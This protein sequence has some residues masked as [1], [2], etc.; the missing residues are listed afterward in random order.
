MSEPCD[1]AD[2]S[3]HSSSSSKP[4]ECATWYRRTRHAFVAALR[5]WA[6]LSLCLTPVAAAASLP[7]ASDWHYGAFLDLSYGLDFNFPENHLWR[8]KSTS[9]RVNELAPNMAMGYVRKDSTAA[10][11][12]GMELGVQA[13]YDTNGLVPSPNPSR[14]TPVDGAD[15][16]RHISRA[17]VSYLAPLGNGLTVTVGLFNS[18]IGYQSVYALDNLNYSRSYMADNAPYFMF[19][20][21]AQYP[22]TDRLQVNL[23]AINGY[24]YLSHPNDQMSYGTQVA[25]RLSKE[26]TVTENLYY[27]PDQSNT[28]LQFW[29]FFSDSIVEWKHDRLTL[30]LA[31]D[32]GT[33][34][35][36]EQPGHPRTFWTAAAFYA[37]L[38]VCGPWSVALRP[39]FYWD[40][41]G[42]ISGS[43]QL[44]KAMTTTVE[45][46]LDHRPSSAVIRLEHRYDESTQPGGGFFTRGEVAPGV[47]G[48]AREQHLLL[49]SLILAF[50]S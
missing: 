13:G 41:S 1:T 50:R 12:W 34:N 22:V 45:Y 43:E 5:L 26:W 18:Y 3:R 9:P 7:E 36:A 38:N 6:C 48:L 10:S 25:Y 31:Y 20:V 46:R 21:A 27:G 29:R 24:N 28:S 8:N 32:F 49:L 44:L 11:R 30:A 2:G 35:A 17:N 47:I 16:L 42:R 15:L 33:E 40:R 19:G 23:Y 39:E 37:R 4:P 14:D